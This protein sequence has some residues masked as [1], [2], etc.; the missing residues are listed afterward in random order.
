MV[1]CP[2]IARRCLSPTTPSSQRHLCV[3]ALPSSDPF[4]SPFNF[5]LSTFNCSCLS[6]LPATLTDGL[7]LVENP[8]TLSPF[9]ATLTRHPTLNPFVCHSYRKRPGW[10]YPVPAKSL[11][12]FFDPKAANSHGIHTYEKCACNFFR[13]RTYKTRHLKSFRIR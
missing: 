10:G 13:I 11:C 1:P 2:V 9:A 6:P 3:P 12:A 4:L 7:Q 5:G 8:A